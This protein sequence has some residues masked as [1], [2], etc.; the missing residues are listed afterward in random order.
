MVVASDVTAVAGAAEVKL[1][2]Q[3]ARRVTAEAQ[4]EVELL[5]VPTGPEQ[6]SVNHSMP[7]DALVS[8]WIDALERG[9][10]YELRVEGTFG[11][12]RL[13]WISP[14]RSFY[15]FI[16]AH[17][18][19]AH[20]LDPDALRK[21]LRNGDLRSVESETLVDRAVRGVMD[22]LERQKVPA[23]HGQG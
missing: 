17:G 18:Q 20:S 16:A 11:R 22:N 4:G 13:A 21:A 6:V 3:S 15:L 23:E 1:S 12:V 14:L 10:W 5:D 19:K 8:D 9:A 2:P 7:S